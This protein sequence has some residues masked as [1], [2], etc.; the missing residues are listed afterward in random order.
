V[1]YS[2]YDPTSVSAP[3][4]TLKDV[5]EERGI[6]PTQLSNQ[7]GCSSE[8]LGLVLDG[9]SPITTGLAA[10]LERALGTPAKFWLAREAR[11][12]EFRNAP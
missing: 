4:E 7:I 5:L 10:E 3:G 11:Y 9:E 12:K 2:E 6:T 1:A 8:E